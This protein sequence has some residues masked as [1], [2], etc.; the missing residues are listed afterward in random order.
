[1]AL[2]TIKAKYIATSVV[3]HEAMLLHMGHGAVRIM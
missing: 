2:N 3:V 1:M